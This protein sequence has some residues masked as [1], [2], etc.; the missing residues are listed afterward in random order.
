MIEEFEIHILPN[1]DVHFIHDDDLAEEMLALGPQEIKRASH[2]EPTH[3]LTEDA[4]VFLHQE[5]LPH[6]IFDRE[7][8]RKRLPKGFWADLIPSN[9][10]VMGPFTRR[11]EAIDAEL[12]WLNANNLGRRPVE[13]GK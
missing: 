9:G 3:D 10:P 11:S 7:E 6:L 12:K 1:G 5:R 4:L 2:I 8:I 13:G